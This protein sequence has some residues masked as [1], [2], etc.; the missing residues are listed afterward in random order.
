[1]LDLEQLIILFIKTANKNNSANIIIDGKGDLFLKSHINKHDII[2]LSNVIATNEIS[3]N[4]ISLRRFADIDLSIY[5]DNKT[6]TNFEKE[7]G[8]EYS[9]LRNYS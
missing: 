5:A 8:S 9:K 2:K 6:F 4:L 1:M 3:D 7:P